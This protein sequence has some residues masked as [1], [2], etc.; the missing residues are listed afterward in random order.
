MKKSISAMISL[1]FLF[2]WILPAQAAPSESELAK[3][4]AS[5]NSKT[6]KIKYEWLSRKKPDGSFTKELTVKSYVFSVE[7]KLL[8]IESKDEVRTLENNKHTGTDSDFTKFSIDTLQINPKIIINKRRNTLTVMCQAN[9]NCV[10]LED[11]SIVYTVNNDKTT[12]TE[13]TRSIDGFDIKTTPLLLDQTSKDLQALLNVL[14][15][16][17]TKP[18]DNTRPDPL[19]TI[20]KRPGPENPV[21]VAP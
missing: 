13:R 14:A 15:T 20:N 11:R 5:L 10:E 8:K 16:P 19:G 4:L 1:F 2:L 12:R 18:A 7:K 17:S 9:K 21:L 6:A 3:L